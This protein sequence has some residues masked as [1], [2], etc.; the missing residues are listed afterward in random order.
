MST[1]VYSIPARIIC[2]LRRWQYPHQTVLYMIT[3]F[4]SL[5]R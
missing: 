4:D 1:S 3:E 5:T 2:A